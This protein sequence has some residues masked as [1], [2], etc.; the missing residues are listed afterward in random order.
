MSTINSNG[1]GPQVSSD[2]PSKHPDG[3]QGFSAESQGDDAPS[4][5]FD[6][7]PTYEMDSPETEEDPTPASAQQAPDKDVIEEPEEELE[8]SLLQGDE[9]TESPKPSRAQKRIKQ[10][11]DQKNELAAK[12]EELLALV[13]Q[14]RKSNEMLERMWERQNALVG[15]QEEA[16]K[17]Q[18]RRN[19]MLQYGLNPDDVRDAITFEQMEYKAQLENQLHTIQQQM[20]EQKYA[21]QVE[22]FNAALDTSLSS[23]LKSFDVGEDV[24]SAIRETAYD[25]AAMRGVTAKEAA[26]EAIGRYRSVLP[27]KAKKAVPARKDAAAKVVTMGNRSQGKS[28]EQDTET[29]DFLSMLDKGNFRL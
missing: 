15:Q 17:L 18:Q 3:F 27:T 22:R 8:P 10:L 13:E 4:E 26:V 23:Q 28:I 6:F 29:G 14:M 21:L 24:F 16:Q 12:N 7:T 5:D 9:G 1:T 20:E 19:M 25:I 2:V 11:A